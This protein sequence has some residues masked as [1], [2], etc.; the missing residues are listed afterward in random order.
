MRRPAPR[1][2]V[3]AR[4]A[5]R[6]VPSWI[7]RGSRRPALAN[8]NGARVAHVDLDLGV[9]FASQVISGT[10]R[11]RAAAVADGVAEL[12]LDTR[13][14]AIDRVRSGD[15]ADLEFTLSE[16][17]EALG[18]ALEV[19]LP[20]S[21]SKGEEFAVV[22]SF[23]TSPSSTAVQFLEPAQ[24]AGGKYPYL[25]TQCQA[26][27]A[28]SLFPCQDAPAAKMT[29]T[30]RVVVPSPLTALMS[31]VPR[32]D[33]RPVAEHGATRTFAFDQAVRSRPIC[34]P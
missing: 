2:R 13:G 20:R 21:L 11:L 14:L 15:G 26:I 17:H 25:F 5:P 30:A 1:G 6:R 12:V 7:T 22:V 10:A 19:T 9:D 3:R 29:Y 8:L 27:H 34:S 32:D 33:G 16:A 28:R 4:W 24:T 18:A 23:S 31:A